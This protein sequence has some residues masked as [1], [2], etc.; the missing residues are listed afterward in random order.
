MSV[1]SFPISIYHN[2]LMS[3]FASA[4]FQRAHCGNALRGALLQRLW[5]VIRILIKNRCSCPVDPTHV[6]VD[7]IMASKEKERHNT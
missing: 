7:G 1:L 6:L 2:K 5:A 4:S 3:L